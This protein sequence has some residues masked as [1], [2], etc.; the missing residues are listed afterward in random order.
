MT[1]DYT[2]DELLQVAIVLSAKIDRLP[3][4]HPA[5]RFRTLITA[6]PKNGDAAPRDDPEFTLDWLA[7]EYTEE[8][9]RST[10]VVPARTRW[11]LLTDRE[12]LEQPEP[13]WLLKDVLFA[14]GLTV[15]YG[16]K[17][18]F[19]SFVALAWALAIG[20]G[21]PWLGRSVTQGLVV[22][23]VAEGAGFFR[24]R[25]AAAR[26]HL[27]LTADDSGVRY[28]TVPVNLFNRDVT[29]FASHVRSQ[30]ESDADRVKLFVFDTF[31][32]SM[33]G[34][35]EN[36]NSD[37]STGV[38]HAQTLQ[39]DFGAAVLLIHHTGK[40][41]L[42]ARG[43]YA[44]E[45]AADL[46]LRLDKTDTRQAVLHFEH[47]KDVEEPAQ[48]HLA[49]VALEQSLVVQESGLSEG[50]RTLLALVPRYQIPCGTS[51]AEFGE[52]HGIPHNSA[53][54]YQRELKG[55]DYVAKGSQIWALT[56]RGEAALVP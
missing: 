52:K 35:R 30:L 22:Y 32:R 28:V 13:A 47:T 31:A 21:Q 10:P 12:L 39:H 26:A 5:R 44:L 6:A 9:G 3:P 18:T 15:L 34:G 43:G 4:D 17:G 38:D 24:R 37:M 27:G 7:D 8:D 45:C 29:A 41:G 33:V 49:L 20:T 16:M 54:R 19:K 53:Y 42:T 14:G 51:L 55:G 11:H 36:D 40:D 46:V 2:R 48:L 1:P 50:A 25:L 56:P 23:I